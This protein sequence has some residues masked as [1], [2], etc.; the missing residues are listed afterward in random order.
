MTQNSTDRL[1][2]KIQFT[3]LIE[4]VALGDVHA[5]A[6]VYSEYYPLIYNYILRHI[7]QIESAQDVTSDVFV[8]LLEKL[9]KVKFNDGNHFKNYLYKIATNKTNEYIRKCMNRKTVSDSECA[10]GAEIIAKATDETSETDIIE[11][12]MQLET[13]YL[14]VYKHLVT[15]KPEYQN[16]IQLRIYENKSYEDI[17]E[18]TGIN[19]NTLKS[20]FLR[21][22]NILKEKMQLIEPNKQY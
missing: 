9:G 6:A 20:H 3:M 22:I 14:K 21:A 17:A 15:L 19:V 4:A 11:N 7:W 18:I 8:A 16:I 2:E 12:Q 13:E 5:F 1:G 10:E